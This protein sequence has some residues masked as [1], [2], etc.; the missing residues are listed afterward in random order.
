MRTF[1]VPAGNVLCQLPVIFWA[2]SAPP[3]NAARAI[4]HNINFFIGDRPTHHSTIHLVGAPA[5]GGKLIVMN[6]TAPQSFT[7]TGVDLGLA[8]GVVSF[9]V[10][11]NFK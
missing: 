7:A 1:C 9:K 10:P 8:T 3:C 4:I 5:G 11:T 6:S 2:S